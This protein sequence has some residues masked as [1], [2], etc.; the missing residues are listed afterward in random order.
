MDRRIR[1]KRWA[2]LSIC[3]E[4]LISIDTKHLQSDSVPG[5]Q[6]D[7][8]LAHIIDNPLVSSVIGSLPKSYYL[9]WIW[10]ATW[11]AA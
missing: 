2:V 4:Y 3:N 5:E 11:L 8:Q 10:P 1:T 7:S 6:R 9:L